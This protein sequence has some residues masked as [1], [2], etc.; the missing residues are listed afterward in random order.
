MEITSLVNRLV[1]EEYIME[2]W[3]NSNEKNLE[4]IRE[5]IEQDFMTSEPFGMVTVEHCSRQARIEITKKSREIIAKDI[6]RLK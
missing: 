3:D 5:L 4:D 6:C 1:K 2:L